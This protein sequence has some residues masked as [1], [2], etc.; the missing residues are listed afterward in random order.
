[1]TNTATL[2]VPTVDRF[3]WAPMLLLAFAV[4]TTVTTE[5]VPAGLLPAMSAAFGV[6]ASGIGLLLSVWA[7]TIAVASLPLVRLARG[8]DRRMLLLV[9]LLV[10]AVANIGIAIAPDLVIAL[11]ARVVAAAAHGVFWSIVMVVAS[12][13]A[14]PRHMGRAVAIAGSGGTA[15]IL[16]GIPIG[17]AIGQFVDWRL[18]FWGLAVLMLAAAAAI[19]LAIPSVPDARPST[20]PGRGRASGMLRIVLVGVVQLFVALGQ[21]TIYTYISPFLTDHAHVPP[22]L[23]SVLLLALGGGGLI[24]LVV[25]GVTADRWPRASLVVALAA[26]GLA[27]SALAALPTATPVVVGATIV[28]GVAIGALPPLLLA[29]TLRV[30]MPSTRSLASATAVVSFNLGIGGGAWLGGAIVDGPGLAALAGVALLAIGAAFAVTV[31][32]FRLDG[33]QAASANAPRDA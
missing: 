5:M 6:G 8:A 33:R 14:P 7:V 21:F 28:W 25:V 23:V 20:D 11:V 22:E 3:A 4:F 27:L 32:S 1:M 2:P 17:T 12:A 24:G 9:A 30:A 10:M 18:A 16:A 19:R 15:A 13:I 31:A 29:R 26:F